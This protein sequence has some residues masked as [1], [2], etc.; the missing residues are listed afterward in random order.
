MRITTVPC[1]NF[2]YM[3]PGRR[4]LSRYMRRVGVRQGNEG[5]MLRYDRK[6]LRENP[7]FYAMAPIIDQPTKTS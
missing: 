5:N 1:T 2:A 6:G 3:L 4:D 7:N